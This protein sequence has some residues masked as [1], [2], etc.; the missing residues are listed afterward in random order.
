MP[1]ARQVPRGTP[2]ASGKP[3]IVTK[4]WDDFHVAVTRDI[5]TLQ[6]IGTYANNA[7]AVAAGVNVGQFYQTATGEVR[8]V[9]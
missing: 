6:P 7:A 4:G 8:V 3:P 1:S 2:V 9:V 5:A